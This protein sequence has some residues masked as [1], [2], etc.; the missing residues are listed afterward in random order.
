MPT[1]FVPGRAHR[2]AVLAALLLAACGG[3]K[4]GT[5]LPTEPVSSGFVVA[6]NAFPFRNFGG[7]DPSAKVYPDSASRMFG[8][9]AVCANAA[10]VEQDGCRLTPI[11]KTWMQN[12]NDAMEGGRCEGFAVLSGLMYIGAEDPATFGATS[13]RDLSLED[14]DKLGREIAYWFS[15][16]YLINVINDTTMPMTATEAVRFLADAFAAG[17][18][19]YRLGIMRID[20]NGQRRGGHAILPVSVVP[21]A[22]PGHFIIK[23]YDNNFP[24][25]ERD[26]LVD[27]NKNRWE[28]QA[29]TNPDAPLTLYWGS[30]ENGNLLF[31]SPVKPRL[32]THPC[33]FCVGD[34]QTQAQSLAQVFALGSAEVTV[35]DANGA[36]TGIKDGKLVEDFVGASVPPMFTDGDNS[37]LVLVPT[38]DGVSV[39]MRSGEGEL[40]LQVAVFG[41]GYTTSIADASNVAGRADKLTLS[42]DGA[43]MNFQPSTTTGPSISMARVT[44]NGTQTVVKL[45]LPEG[46]AVTSV[47]MQVNTETGDAGIQARAEGDVP[48]QIEVT[49]STGDGEDSFQAEIVAPAEGAVEIGV[50]TWE[51][52][53]AP[54][55]VGVDPDGSGN[56]EPTEVVST[57]PVGVGPTAPTDLVGVVDAG[58][59]ALTWQDTSTNEESFTVE[60]DAGLGF[61]VL[62]TTSPN[63][64]TFADPNVVAGRTY[65]YRVRA[66]NRYDVSAWSNEIAVKIP[67]C[68]AGEQDND[69][70][71]TCAPTCATS[72]LDCGANGTCSDT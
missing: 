16:Q 59:V 24:E 8:A 30:P 51:G 32:G 62:G 57:G 18:D 35:S 72:G 14:N 31:L 17:T 23:V 69:G 12:V 6:T 29:S 20:E 33:P 5:T 53:G 58:G 13:A 4:D 47:S 44:I 38:R 67:G 46:M 55:P 42:A 3:A 26:I 19:M 2:A 63:V 66:E 7:R 70:D 15:S 56:F 28:Y 10:D 52:E 40:P 9:S 45:K 65:H 22:E 1:N 68:P 71:E 43:D 25:T 61:E 50:S 21:A 64:A 34:E 36:E 27:T 60:R 48:L 54:M 41:A 37:K 11:A 49:R 39:T